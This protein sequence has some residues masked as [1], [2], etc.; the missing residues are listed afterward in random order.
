MKIKVRKK[1]YSQVVA[2]K[3]RKHKL[4]KRPSMVLRKLICLISKKEIKDCQVTFIEK[5]MEKLGKKEPCL[6][7]MNHSCFLDLKIAFTYFKNR[8][9]NI[10]ATSDGFVGKEGLMR[11]IGCIPTDKFVY[12]LSLVKD[13]DYALKHKRS[14]LMYPEAGYSFDGTAIPLPESLGKLIKFLK[15]PVVTL[16]TDGAFLHNPLYNNL[17]VRNTKVNVRATYLLSK[18]DIQTQS[19]EELN[20]CMKEIFGFDAFK[21]Q[22]ENSVCVGEKFRADGLERILYKCP[23]CMGENMTAGEA[24]IRCR[25][26]GVVYTL[27]EYGVLESENPKF[28]HIPD[29]CAWEREEVRKEIENGSYTL[30]IPVKIGVL[31]NYKA[32]YAVGEG[33]L[34]HNQD[35]FELIGEDGLY[36]KQAPTVSYTLNSDFYWY[37][38]GD[39]ISIGDKEYLYYCFPMEACA[40][41]KTRFAVEA[42]YK[43]HKEKRKTGALKEG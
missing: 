28:T 37:E 17:Q 8:A 36:Y 5:D 25:D 3:K 34:K 29:W 23:H 30:D 41:S 14:V 11:H 20:A 38:M 42:L 24:E 18:E 4:P 33:R 43:M 39:I 35:G 21:A 16:I 6:I 12:D 26:C 15:V 13:I 19:A 7:L 22:H 40:V 31:A 1:R 27:N 10:V 2:M 32:V 9:F